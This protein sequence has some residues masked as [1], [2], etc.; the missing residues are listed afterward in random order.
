M[1]S[2]GRAREPGTEVST[3]QHTMGKTTSWVQTAHLQWPER[4]LP[5]G[6]D[7]PLRQ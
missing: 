7:D 6:M 2:R 3:R 5:L 4:W 1:A